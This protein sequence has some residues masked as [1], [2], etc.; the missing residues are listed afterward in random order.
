MIKANTENYSILPKIIAV[1]FDGIITV[2]DNFPNIGELRPGIISKLNRLK[3]NGF[4][5]ILWTC[6]TE[7]YL[8]EAVEFCKTNGLTF[9]AI[10]DNIQEVKDHYGQ[11][12]RKIFADYY[13]DD[14][15]MNIFSFYE[16]WGKKYGEREFN[17]V[18]YT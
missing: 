9:D 16:M 5:L 2:S 15:N 3:Q 14:K 11:N 8:S 7:P 6:R 12:P 10:N 17:C 1:D 13:L 18:I 4:R